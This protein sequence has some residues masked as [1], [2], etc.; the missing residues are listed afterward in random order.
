M[1][2]TKKTAASAARATTHKDCD[3]LD[4]PRGYQIGPSLPV[5]IPQ[6]TKPPFRAQYMLRVGCELAIGPRQSAG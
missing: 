1:P 6:G 2:P 3:C 4:A 5:P